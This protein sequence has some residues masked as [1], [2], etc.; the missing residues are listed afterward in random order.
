[1]EYKKFYDYEQ[2]LQEIDFKKALKILVSLL[3]LIGLAAAFYNKQI[4]QD[5]AVWFFRIA[6][7]KYFAYDVPHRRYS[8]MIVQIPTVIW[9]HLNDNMR[10]GGLVFNFSYFAFP[11]LALLGLKGP[12]RTHKPDLIYPVLQ[13]FLLTV[14]PSWGF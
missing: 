4:F 14:V 7:T 5:A 8:G 1:M 12:I 13:S 11:F 2:Y 6:N 3:F 10:L 9:S